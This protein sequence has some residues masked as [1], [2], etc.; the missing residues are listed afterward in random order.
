[1]KLSVIQNAN[2]NDKL[3]LVRVDHNVE[4]GVI[5]PYRIDATFQ[6]LFYI[7]SPVANDTY[8]YIGRQIKKMVLSQ[9][10]IKPVYYLLSNICI[11]N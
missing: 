4:N 10:L 11:I 9:F 8:D 6:T 2:L 5:R 1:M 7:A 3:V